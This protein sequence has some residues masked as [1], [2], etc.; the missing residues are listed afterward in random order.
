MFKF[1]LIILGAV[2]EMEQE[3]TVEQIRE[4]MSKTKR[5]G[6]G[7]GH[8][9]GRPTREIPTSFKKYYPMWKGSEITATDFAWLIG[10]SRPTLYQYIR[11]HEAG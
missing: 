9:A 11:E 4:G 3:I 8:P 5:Y 2:A 7:S 6:T 1:M 10:V